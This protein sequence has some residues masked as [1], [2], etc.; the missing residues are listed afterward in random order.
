VL[1]T[2]LLKNLL[3]AKSCSPNSDTAIKCRP[4]SNEIVAIS[5][6]S[7]DHCHRFNHVAR[8]LALFLWDQ[9]LQC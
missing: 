1:K 8:L 2:F 7:F 6:N 4:A 9:I 5:K 3:H